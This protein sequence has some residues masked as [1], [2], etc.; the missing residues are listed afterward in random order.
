[1]DTLGDKLWKAK[2]RESNYGIRIREGIERL[3]ITQEE[4]AER[5]GVTKGSVNCY[6]NSRSFP[7]K[8]VLPRLLKEL[9]L[10]IEELLE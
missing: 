8:S 1:M 10:T 2:K 4:F 9:N 5:I 6:V 3:G 7:Q